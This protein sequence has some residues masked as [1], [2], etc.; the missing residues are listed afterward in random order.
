MRRLAIGVAAAVFAAAVVG[1]Q[2]PKAGTQAPAGKP[3]AKP[4]ATKGIPRSADGKPDF[5]GNWTNA[6]I[7]PLERLGSGPLVITEEAARAVESST[8]RALEAREQDSDPNRG[9]PPR[10]GGPGADAHPPPPP[11]QAHAATAA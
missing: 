3:P 8:Q 4:A 2:A 9:A 10:G 11:H 7:T 6:T 5:T 1:A